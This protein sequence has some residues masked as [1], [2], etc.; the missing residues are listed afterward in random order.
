MPDLLIFGCFCR[1]HILTMVCIFMAVL[2]ELQKDVHATE[3]LILS[4][5]FSP[6]IRNSKRSGHTFQ[7][8]LFLAMHISQICAN[9][10]S[11]TEV[12]EYP[13]GTVA[14]K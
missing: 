13:Y 10:R 5:L 9:K 1:S 6:L 14:L 3:I 12:T 7:C 11:Q 2:L 8:C 4:I